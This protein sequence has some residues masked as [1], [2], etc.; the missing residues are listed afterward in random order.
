MTE[1]WKD[2]V[3][4]EGYYQVSNFGRVKSLAR[5]TVN[6]RGNITRYKERIL[7][8]KNANLTKYEQASLHKDGNRTVREVHRL[9]AET[10][11]PN[12]NNYNHVNHKD[13]NTRNNRVDNL[14]WCTQE[15]NNQN[16]A[17]CLKF[18]D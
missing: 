11:I 3:G 8:T 9:V 1:I 10:F 6:T 18:R 5:T 2:I 15:Y 16:R 4:F 13:H 14:E 7:S 12:P 17:N